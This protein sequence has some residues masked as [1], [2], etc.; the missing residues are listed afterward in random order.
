MLLPALRI[1]TCLALILALNACGGGDA[2]DGSTD[3]AAPEIVSTAPAAGD[4]VIT[5]DYGAYRLTYDCT[6]RT[7]LDYHYTL[8]RDTGTLPRPSAFTLDTTL[9]AGC[10]Q[11]TTTASYES[12]HSGYDRGHLVMSNH[13]DHDADALRR[14]NHMTNIAPQVSSFNRGI[15]LDAESVAECY[16]DIAPVQVHGGVVY[17]DP[18][19]DHFLASHGIRTPE[20]FWKALITTDPATGAARAIAWFIP[21][22]EGLTSLDP[23]LVS[24]A[25]LERL[26]GADA[27]RIDAPD[28]VKAMKPAATWPLPAGCS[29][30]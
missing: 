7:A 22:R 24:I 25:D 9:P 1:P 14:A 17:T 11:Q 27:V 5:Q 20:Y 21:N 6:Q 3:P 18:S 23:W 12:V 28:A 13:M 15:W 4:W 29:M 8:D 30:S 26:I 19:N 10:A 2:G 16:R